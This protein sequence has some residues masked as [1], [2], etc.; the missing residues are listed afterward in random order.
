MK[1]KNSKILICLIFVFGFVF[2][3]FGS[4]LAKPKMY[5]F[6]GYVT[7]KVGDDGWASWEQLGYP[8]ISVGDWFVCSFFYSIDNEPDII[9]EDS[10]NTFYDTSNLFFNTTIQFKNVFVQN[11]YGAWAMID[12]NRTKI[13]YGFFDSAYTKLSM[14]SSRSLSEATLDTHEFKF[15]LSKSIEGTGFPDSIDTSSFLSGE[16]KLEWLIDDV[17]LR[18]LDLKCKIISIKSV[19]AEEQGGPISCTLDPKFSTTTMQKNAYYYIDRDYRITGGFSDWMIGRTL[20]QTPND[21]R[22]D[23]SD[24]GYVR[25]TNPVDWWV[26][27]LFDSRSKSIPDWLKGWQLRSEKIT[28]SLSTQPYMKLYRKQFAAGECVDLGGNY[29]PGSSK[30]NRSNY[31]VVYGK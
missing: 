22:F 12:S 2:L 8:T 17:Y 29:G 1:S 24:S 28:T 26:Y 5:V 21:E 25:F 7:D 11:N 20:I 10:N 31:A 23:E 3:I 30:E 4:A 6:S 16:M 13:T 9:Q 15:N 27:V 19:T 18:Q 14:V